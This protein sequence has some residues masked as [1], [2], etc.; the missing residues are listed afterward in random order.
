M[1]TDPRIQSEVSPQPNQ[2]LAL[3][4][5]RALMQIVPRYVQHPRWPTC[6]KQCC[7]PL[8]VLLL[9]CSCAASH[10]VAAVVP[11]CRRLTA[12]IGIMAK[13]SITHAAIS[14]D[15]CIQ[16]HCWRRSAIQQRQPRTAVGRS[17]VN[18]G[19]WPRWQLYTLGHSASHARQARY[20]DVWH[21]GRSCTPQMLTT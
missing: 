20:T 15:T 13:L 18:S 12:H 21:S 2:P 6:C 5:M 19:G 1:S 7:L 11:V 16:K 10:L 17:V 4:L 9:L 8:A 14:C 3:A